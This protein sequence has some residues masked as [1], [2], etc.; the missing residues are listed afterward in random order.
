MV[1]LSGDLDIAVL[2]NATKQLRALDTADVAVID[3]RSVTYIDSAA[4][5][6]L[7]AA[8][9]RVISSGGSLRIVSADKRVK[10][11]LTVTGIDK[12]VSVYEELQD[13]LDAPR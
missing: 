11:L 6:M 13:A 3:M 4:L 9:D 7:V 1:K 5:G 8:R 12:S 2:P 10:R